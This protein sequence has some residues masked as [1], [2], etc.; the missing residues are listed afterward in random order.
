MTAAATARTIDR[1][2]ICGG[3]HLDSVL[4]LGHVPPVNEMVTI[5]ERPAEQNCYPLEMLRCRDCG[6]AQIGCAVSAEVLFPHSYPYLSGTTRILRDNFADLYAETNAMLNLKPE[7]LAVDIG[8]N[9]GSLLINFL[10]GG[11][12]VLGVEPSQAGDVAR[13]RGIDTRTGYFGREEAL[14]LAAEVGKARVVTA[15]N[16]FAHI[17]DVHNVV[18]GILELLQPGG[19]FISEN[20]Y[21]GDLLRTVQYDTIYHEHLRYYAL[22]SLEKLFASHGL[23]VFHVHRIPT[24]GGSIRVF[25]ARKGDFEVRDSVAELRREEADAGVDDGSAFKELARRTRDS[26]LGLMELLARLKR[27][28]ARVYGVG[29][30][31]RASTLITYT[32]LDDGVIDC[33]LEVSGSNK[34]NKYMPGTRIPVLE[35][36]KLFE[37]QP[38][39]A[40]LLSWHIADEIAGNL[41]RKGF[42]G[43]FIAPLPEPRVID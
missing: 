7:D 8:S 17:D 21:L 5:G 29:A 16:V 24:H 9:D 14:K 33:V 34:L 2:Q 19:V 40:L 22:G 37:D 26:K 38:E 20:H 23:E 4:F 42:R 3:V 6:L 41:R 15:C 10:N 27:E 18:K 35:E 39:Y 13:G 30:P 1:C 36:S 28:G 11:H 31:S 43:K 12:R 25:A 32:G